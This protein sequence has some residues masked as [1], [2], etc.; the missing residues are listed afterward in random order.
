MS[1]L[2]TLS[3]QPQSNQL[4]YQG[5]VVSIDDSSKSGILKIKI[6]GL[7][8]DVADKD[9]PPAYPIFNFAFFRV[10]PKKGERV[11]VFLEKGGSESRFNQEKRYWIG[12]S[13]STIANINYDPYYYTAS[14]HESDGWVKVKN[15]TGIPKAIG[16]YP[17]EDHI[18]IY[19]RK[20]TDLLFKDEE[21]ILR[22]GR[23]VRNNPLEF[24]KIDPAYIQIK[25]NTNTDYSKEIKTITKTI[26]L[27]PEYKITAGLYGVATKIKIFKLS[28]DSL[29]EE[30]E[31]SFVSE[32]ETIAK[33]KEK[34]L[35]YQT[36]YQKFIFSSENQ[37]FRN[38][39]Q[40]FKSIK[41][42]KEQVPVNNQEKRPIENSTINIVANRINILS[43]KTNSYKLTDPNYIVDPFEQK[44]IEDEAHPMVYGDKLIEL[45]KL[46]KEFITTHVHPYNGMSPVKDTIVQK[47]LNYDLTQIINENIK[48]N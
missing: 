46:I 30:Y 33:A 3:N 40:R 27:E 1:E 44:K 2:Y 42:I 7:D 21:I 11:F 12:I 32:N 39:P 8:N 16:T 23:H 9:L 18:G 47:I 4:L 19:G 14:S 29:V 24:N 25:Y 37:E 17:L 10:L 13:V 48:I 6:L 31:E 38:L 41:T 22:S 5:E 28:D 34:I 36:K 43:H 20:N 26:K 15:V 45:L 35:E